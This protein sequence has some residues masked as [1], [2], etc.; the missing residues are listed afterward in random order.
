MAGWFSDRLTALRVGLW[1]KTRSRG[2]YWNTLFDVEN[3]VVT[4][5]LNNHKSRGTIND[6]D[7]NDGRAIV[8]QIWKFLCIPFAFHRFSFLVMDQMA[9]DP[10]R[11][12][13]EM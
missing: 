9:P 7:E 13:R 1:S 3:H 11:D 10:R 5:S 4:K 6:V 12:L 2:P 8:C